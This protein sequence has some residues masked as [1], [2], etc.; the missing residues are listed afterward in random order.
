METTTIRLKNTTKKLLD[1]L[2]K[3]GE[4]YDEILNKLI[5]LYKEKNE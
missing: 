4:S 5:I 3:K 2:G 1:K